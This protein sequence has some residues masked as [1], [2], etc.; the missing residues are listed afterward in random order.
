[1]NNFIY[2]H[3]D[4]ERTEESFTRRKAEWAETPAWRRKGLC[5]YDLSNVSKC[6]LVRVRQSKEDIAR[7]FSFQKQDKRL[8]VR[9]EVHEILA[10]QDRLQSLHPWIDSKL[11]GHSLKETTMFELEITF[12]TLTILTLRF[13]F[14]TKIHEVAEGTNMLALFS[15]VYNEGDEID[16]DFQYDSKSYYLTVCIPFWMWSE[17]H[18]SEC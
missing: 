10:E 12:T 8:Q 6:L 18:S 2:F 15:V 3:K 13:L 16:S 17:E 9:N 11:T 1:M 14:K 7:L 5:L 4:E